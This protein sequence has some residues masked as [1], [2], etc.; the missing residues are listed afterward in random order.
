VKD[1]SPLKTLPT[2]GVYTLIIYLNKETSLKMQKLDC[3]KLQ[4]GYY[5]Y[6]GS[7]VGYG[8]VSL[9]KR[10]ARHLKKRKVRHWHIDFLIANKNATVVDVVAAESDVNR[11]CQV[12]KVIMN[13]DG[14]TVP[15]AGFGA[16]DCKQH[17]KS[18]LVRFP[19]E[20]LKEKIVNAY[21][22]L[23]GTKTTLIFHQ[24]MRI[25]CK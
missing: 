3:F 4:K 8:P 7:A 16:S 6:T 22:H 5:T 21:M 24:R 20:R 17:C 18:H 15:I 9:K 25:N 23:F 11:E 12:N 10:V 19:E 13:I 1:L 2:K 14:A